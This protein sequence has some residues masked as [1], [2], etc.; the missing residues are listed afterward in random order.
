[1]H[2]PN[3]GP[4]VIPEVDQDRIEMNQTAQEMELVLRILAQTLLGS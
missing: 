3:L 1:M 4:L 2:V